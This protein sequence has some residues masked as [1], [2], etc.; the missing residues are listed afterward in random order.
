MRV[1]ELLQTEHLMRAATVF[2]W[3]V[4]LKKQFGIMWLYTAMETEAYISV[5]PLREDP[6][7]SPFLQ[8]IGLGTILLSALSKIG[9]LFGKSF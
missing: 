9:E 1:L 8:N 7:M 2:I 5:I 4:I 3:K 6:G